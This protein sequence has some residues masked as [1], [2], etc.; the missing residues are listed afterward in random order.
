MLQGAVT[1]FVQ[2]ELCGPAITELPALKLTDTDAWVYLGAPDK[3]GGPQI[4]IFAL[5]ADG[6]HYDAAIV[7]SPTVARARKKI[8]ESGGTVVYI[9]V[10]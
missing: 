1:T 10:E 5:R 6:W 3:C 9:R 4:G 8:Q 7:D 2:H